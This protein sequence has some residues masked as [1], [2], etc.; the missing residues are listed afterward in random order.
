M[1]LAAMEGG[2]WHQSQPDYIMAWD[3]YA[4]LFQNIA[5][6]RPRFHDLD[7]RSIVALIKR[8]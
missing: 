6:Q 7:H 1:D 2:Q 8:G 5:I 4:K 3:G